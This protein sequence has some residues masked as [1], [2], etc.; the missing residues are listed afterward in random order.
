MTF[1]YRLPVTQ[2]LNKALISSPSLIFFSQATSRLV[3][4]FSALHKKNMAATIATL[5]TE[6]VFNKKGLG[7]LWIKYQ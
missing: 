4:V 6:K 1:V 2:L 5:E 3:V 7:F